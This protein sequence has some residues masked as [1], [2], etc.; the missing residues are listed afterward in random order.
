MRVPLIVVSVVV[1]C[2]AVWLFAFRSKAQTASNTCSIGT[3]QGTYG[4]TSIT[5][6]PETAPVTQNAW[7]K[8]GATIATVGQMVFDGQGGWRTSYTAS[9][10]DGQRVSESRTGEYT[11]SPDCFGSIHATAKTGGTHFVIVTESA[12]RDLRFIGGHATG[13]AFRQDAK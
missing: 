6:Y 3:L 11:L 4:F 1:V 5:H 13:S 7:G 8:A 10:A 2:G 12:G 9:L